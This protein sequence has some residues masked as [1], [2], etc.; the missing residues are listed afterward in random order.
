MTCYTRT[1]SNFIKRLVTCFYQGICSAKYL[2]FTR[3]HRSK[4][5]P[6]SHIGFGF[7][8]TLRILALMQPKFCQRVLHRFFYLR[9]LKI[10]ALNETSILNFLSVTKCAVKK[11]G[12]WFTS[13]VNQ[14]GQYYENLSNHTTMNIRGLNES[15]SL[16]FM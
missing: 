3:N 12:P 15:K 10:E 16:Q 9:K 14:F 6:S 7:S 4:P 5:N 13:L 8:T 1:G 2:I 11:W